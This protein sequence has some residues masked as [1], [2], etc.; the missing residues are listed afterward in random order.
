MSLKKLIVGPSVLCVAVLLAACSNGNVGVSSSNRLGFASV[1]SFGDSLSDVGAYAAGAI[2]AVG[3]GRWTVNSSSAKNWTELLAGNY[4]LTTCA[5]LVGFQGGTSANGYALSAAMPIT[6]YAGCYNYAEGGAVVTTTASGIDYPVFPTLSVHDQIQAHL[7]RAEIGGSFSG[8]ELVT[9]LVGGN[10]LLN[11]LTT[12]QT[13]G[14]SAA[15]Q[16]AV[17]TMTQAGTDLAND[18]NTLIL[19]KGAKYVV[20]LNLPDASKTPGSVAQ[21]SAAQTLITQMVQAFNTAL[22]SGLTGKTGVVYVDTFSALD[23]LVAH[24][25]QYGLTNV[26]AGACNLTATSNILGKALTCTASNTLTGVDV[27]RYY[28]ADS[29]GHLTPYGYQLLAQLVS[30]SLVQAGWY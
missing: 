19:Q 11:A 25:A 9:V 2:R 13:T 4:G 26:T 21:G 8:K 18:V 12:Y 28:F 7:G 1:V 22:S 20:V 27:S 3:G 15:A 16:T 17:A 10:D 14:G 29:T 5:A 24:P 6:S 23:D 30:K